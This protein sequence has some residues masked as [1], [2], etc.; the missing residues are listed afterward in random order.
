MDVVF[1]DESNLY[2]KKLVKPRL[3]K[4][5]RERIPQNLIL[6]ERP[7]CGGLELMVFGNINFNVVGK[8]TRIRSHIDA[9][10]FLNIAEHELDWLELIDNEFIFQHDKCGP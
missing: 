1:S 10:Y 9:E 2:A 3:K 8:L 6:Q 7:W 4:H 5:R